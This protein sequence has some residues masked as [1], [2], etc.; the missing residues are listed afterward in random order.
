MAKKPIFKFLPLVFLL[1]SAAFAHG[2]P[3][4]GPREF[5][6][7]IHPI[8]LTSNIR[9]IY[10]TVQVPLEEYGDYHIIINP[11]LLLSSL[12]KSDYYRWGS[13]IGI[14]RFISGVFYLQLMPSIFQLEGSTPDNLIASG[15]MINVLGYIGINIGILYFDVGI[16]YGW[17]SLPKTL[18]N[19]S[20]F[21]YHFKN[22]RGFALD[23]NFGFL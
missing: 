10:L 16:G 7:S 1:H 17:V 12:N 11:S 13:G 22:N 18:R 15:A 9:N 14:R 19:Y 6:I 23:V 3:L 2:D 21:P 8:T 5:Q 4:P 20:D